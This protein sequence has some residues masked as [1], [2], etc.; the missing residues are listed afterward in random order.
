MN[1]FQE[2]GKKLDANKAGAAGNAEDFTKQFMSD[3]F[4]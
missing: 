1:F 4:G 2:W 3:F